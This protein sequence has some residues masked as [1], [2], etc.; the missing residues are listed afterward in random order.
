MSGVDL[1]GRLRAS[2]VPVPR[3]AVEVADGL[4]VAVYKRRGKKHNIKISQM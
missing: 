2:S 1:G 4:F 3:A